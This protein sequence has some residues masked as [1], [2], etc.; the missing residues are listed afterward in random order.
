MIISI[1]YVTYIIKMRICT[2]KQNYLC[3]NNSCEIC[4]SRSLRK[5]FLDN[6]LSESLFIKC[7]DKETLTTLTISYGSHRRCLFKC[8]LCFHIYE[9]NPGKFTSRK[10]C[11]YC[12]NGGNS[13][14]CNDSNCQQCY[15]N[16]LAS[17]PNIDKYWMFDKND[18][19]PRDI[20]IQSNLKQWF[21][22]KKC[23]HPY[24]VV[25]ASFSN[26]IGCVYCTSDG[27]SL[28]DDDNCEQCHNNSF[29]I[30]PMSKF[31]NYKKNNITPRSLRLNSHQECWFICH[32][33]NN[34]YCSK[35]YTIADGHW[36]GCNKKKTETKFYNWLSDKYNQYTII[37]Q[38][39][40]EPINTRKFDFYIKELNLI[41]EVDGNQ[42]F[43]QVLNW[44][45]PEYNR[46]IDILKTYY[47]NKHG[48]SIIRI[49]Q[50]DIWDDKNSWSDNLVVHIKKYDNPKNIYIGNR[51]DKHKELE[52]YTKLVH[53]SV[54]NTDEQSNTIHYV[55]K[56]IKKFL[57]N[58]TKFSININDKLN[59]L[60]MKIAKAFNIQEI[61][62]YNSFK[63]FLSHVL[64]IQ[65]NMNI[66]N[67]KLS[68]KIDTKTSL[69]YL[70]K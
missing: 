66:E 2:S 32:L 26:G 3:G 12:T 50:E 44:E 47:A 62:P 39:T 33:C 53:S 5:W 38:Y 4:Y 8:K 42:H 29:A 46:R 22:C 57:D 36:C 69:Y 25:V 11:V 60:N 35:L 55:I 23:L 24:Y 15:S 45:S 49:P 65:Y 14:L 21:K 52:Y 43:H 20:R 17:I 58:Y 30:H 27:G 41:I 54:D 10:G 9:I 64:G 63:Y 67:E 51:Y 28:C 6:D 13:L 19:K 1:I 68:I 31:W 61:E 70:I 37:Q 7:L 48:V 40:I 16:S 56:S 18:I 34:D 59:D